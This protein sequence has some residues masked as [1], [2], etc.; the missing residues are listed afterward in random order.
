M[1]RVFYTCCLKVT[2]L[3]HSKQERQCCGEAGH[4]CRPHGKC[5]NWPMM[6][7]FGNKHILLFTFS[8]PQ[9]SASASL[10]LAG[11]QAPVLDIHEVARF[12]W[13]KECLR[14][15]KN[16]ISYEESHPCSHLAVCFM[17]PSPC[18]EVLP[19]AAAGEPL[20]L[21]EIWKLSWFSPTYWSTMASTTGGFPC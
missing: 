13:G 18:P 5:K 1:P 8:L 17:A 3:T 4:T 15:M 11:S 12:L 19:R 10:P 14:G 20:P 9:L 6:Q 2:V 7:V 16:E 21:G